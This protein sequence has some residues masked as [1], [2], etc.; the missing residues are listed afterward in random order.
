M[1]EVEDLPDD[2]QALTRRQAF[3]LTTRHWAKDVEELIGYL[4]QVRGLNHTRSAVEADQSPGPSPSTTRPAAMRQRAATTDICEVR[5]GDTWVKSKDAAAELPPGT[6]FRDAADSPE[7]VVMPA[8]SFLM[9]SPESEPSRSDDEGP[10]H[11]V[12]IA[13]PFAVG[14]YAVTFDEW[15]RCVDAGGSQHQPCDFGWGR[16][17]RPVIDVNWDDAQA[18]VAWLAEKT[19]KD[20]RLLSEAEWE[21]AARAGTTTAYPWADEPGTGHANLDGSGSEWS[22]SQT[23]PVGRFAPNGFGLYDMIGNVLEWTQ[24]CWNESYSG[25]PADGSPWEKGDCGRRVVRGG[26]WYISLE[27]A[28]AAYRNMN[29]PAIRDINLGFRLARTL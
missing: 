29:G 24:D 12:T 2:L 25:A 13:R 28:R 3:P 1:P 26:S 6:V 7:M 18:Y 17:I 23:S 22:G 8:G 5:H 4:R 10:Q 9:G 15:D 21:Y 20:Y 27:I 11:K 14:R 16:G 19:G